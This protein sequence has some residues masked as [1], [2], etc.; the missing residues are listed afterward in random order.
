[1]VYRFQEKGSKFVHGLCIGSDEEAA[2]IAKSLGYFII[3]RPGVSKNGDNETYRSEFKCDLVHEEDSHFSRNRKIVS[4][5]DILLATPGSKPLA[6][7]GGTVYTIGIAK[8]TSKPCIIIYPDGS[9][10]VRK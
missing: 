9:V 1:M 4:E 5:C 8:K 3:G 6:E 7:S 2:D 10:E